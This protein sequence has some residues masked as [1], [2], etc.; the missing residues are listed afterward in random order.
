M[1]LSLFTTLATGFVSVG[2][3]AG[4]GDSPTAVSKVPA[5]V[6]SG[7]QSP[8]PT[9]TTESPTPKAAPNPVTILKQIGISPGPSVSSGTNYGDYRE[10]RAYYKWETITI[11]TFTDQ[12]AKSSIDETPQDGYA[13]VD[14]PN[15]VV[16]IQVN[17][18]PNG[19]GYVFLAPYTPQEIAAK[20]GGTV[21]Q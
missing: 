16:T 10:T 13:Y 7:T 14:G 1:R 19:P 2:I 5:T 8:A 21:R 20:V 4:C 18:N 15:F 3:L 9:A 11:D 17:A 12:A 6:A